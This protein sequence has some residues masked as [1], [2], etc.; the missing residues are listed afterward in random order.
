MLNVLGVDEDSVFANCQ[1][2]HRSFLPRLLLSGSDA[3][4]IGTSEEALFTRVWFIVLANTSGGTLLV[5]LD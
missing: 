3:E 5:P 2:W 1:F 4:L